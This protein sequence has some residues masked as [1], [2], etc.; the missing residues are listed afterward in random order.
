M[1][2]DGVQ[3]KRTVTFVVV[4]EIQKFTYQSVERGCPAVLRRGVRVGDVI[5]VFVTAT[6][7]AQS[8]CQHGQS[9]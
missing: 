2:S 1:S 5:D 4:F 3:G 6:P 9:A 7:T 8:P